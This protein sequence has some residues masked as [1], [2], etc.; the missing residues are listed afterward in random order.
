[1]TRSG[2]QLSGVIT[3]PTNVQVKCINVPNLSELDAFSSAQA[4]QRNTTLVKFA[5]CT[6]LET[7]QLNRAIA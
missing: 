7:V 5:V 4:T 6:L 2:F 3:N 1:M